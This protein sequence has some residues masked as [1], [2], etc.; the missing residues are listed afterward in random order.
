MTSP[1][2]ERFALKST[3]MM[4]LAG[5]GV[6]VTTSVRYLEATKPS[7]DCC[8]VVRPVRPHLRL[9]TRAG[10]RRFAGGGEQGAVGIIVA[11][12]SV[13][14]YSGPIVVGPPET[15]NCASR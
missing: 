9:E 3:A 1:E 10:P 4:A 12:N 6:S 13:A 11:R 14:S 5:A 8:N 15:N 2:S 7:M